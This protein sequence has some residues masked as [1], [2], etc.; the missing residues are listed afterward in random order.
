MIRIDGKYAAAD[1]FVGGYEDLD[2]ASY[3]QIVQLLSV[4]CMEGSKIAI[5]PDVHAGV[6]CV[7]GYTQT[8]TDRIVPNLVG[9]D[10]A[11]GMLVCKV[12]SEYQF[13]YPRLDKVVRQGIPCGM[14]HRQTIHKFAKNVDLGG[15]VANVDANKLLYSI[16]TLG[17]GN[18]F[19]AVEVDSEGNSCIIIHSGSRYLGNAVCRYHQDIAI[20]RYLTSRKDTGDTTQF[21][22][23][24]AWVEGTATEDYLNDMNICATFS[25]WN[26]R[27][28]LQVILDGM[29]IKNRHILGTFTTLHNYVDVENR[30]IRKG[31]ISLNDGERAIIPLNMRDGSLIVVGKGNPDA[32]FSGPHGAGRV[33]S[34]GTAKATLSMDEFKESITPHRFRVGP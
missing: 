31:S 1:V 16:G 12:S 28:M 8:F 26:R 32:N 7:V 25:D 30:I 27:A 14:A 19:I 22:S 20:K 21:P 5:M 23:N 2:S 4:P 3:G 34:R 15:L 33:L 29:G 9:V 10:I 24:L 6:G 17:G 18:H 11:C 13:D